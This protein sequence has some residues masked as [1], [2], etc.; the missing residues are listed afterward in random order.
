M[1]IIIYREKTIVGQIF[2]YRFCFLCLDVYYIQDNRRLNF[3][4]FY[5]FSGKFPFLITWLF[6][7]LNQQQFISQKAHRQWLLM[8]V[9]QDE[10][11]KTATR[12]YL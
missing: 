7:C 11:T 4:V 5:L 2:S 12:M 3:D 6:P 9:F 10:K 1:P 8:L